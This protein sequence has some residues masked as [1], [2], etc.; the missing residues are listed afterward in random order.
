MGGL[1]PVLPALPPARPPQKIYTL[2]A[3]SPALMPAA[4]ASVA[5]CLRPGSGRLLFRDY[6]ATDAVK[7]A[8]LAGEAG[9]KRIADGF[10]SRW[11]GTRAFFF[12]EARGVGVG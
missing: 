3:V 5:A 9:R 4:L 1:Q 12:S 6:A 8:Q 7:R 11:D 2:C 10:Y